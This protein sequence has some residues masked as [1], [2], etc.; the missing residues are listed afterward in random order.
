[1]GASGSS[2]QPQCCQPIAPV[3]QPQYYVVPVF[4][5]QPV[6]YVS[7]QYTRIC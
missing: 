6:T 7:Y 4:Q 1:M 3:Y 2:N 5:P